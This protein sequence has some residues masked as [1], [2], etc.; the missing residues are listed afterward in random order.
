MVFS[1]S[2]GLDSNL[3]VAI[4]QKI[5]KKEKLLAIQLIPT[6]IQAQM[7]LQMTQGMQ[8]KLQKLLDCRVA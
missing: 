2:G 7:V 3:I 6:Q 5:L 1:L 4:A 8:E